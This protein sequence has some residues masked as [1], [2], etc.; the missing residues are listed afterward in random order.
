MKYLRDCLSSFAEQFK[1]YGLM[2]LFVAGA[3]YSVCPK[4]EIYMPTD[5]PFVVVISKFNKITGQGKINIFNKDTGEKFSEQ[6]P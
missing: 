4:Y 1:K 3:I 2:I 6:K 5:S